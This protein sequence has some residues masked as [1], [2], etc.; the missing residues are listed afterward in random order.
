[1]VQT[2]YWK[3]L[4]QAYLFYFQRLIFLKATVAGSI[5]RAEIQVLEV[6]CFFFIMNGL[7]TYINLFKGQSQANPNLFLPRVCRMFSAD[8]HF[9]ESCSIR[10]P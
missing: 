2:E 6:K 9:H 10:D 8:A 4:L 5:A 7:C 3:Q 1:M